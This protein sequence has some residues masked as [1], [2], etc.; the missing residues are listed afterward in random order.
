MAFREIPANPGLPEVTKG[1]FNI[2]QAVGGSEVGTGLP[3]ANRPTDMMLVYY[4]LFTIYR[5]GDKSKFP[6]HGHDGFSPASYPP[7]Q[8]YNDSRFKEKLSSLIYRFQSDVRKLGHPVFVDGRCDRGY[9][10]LTPHTHTFYT[11]NMLNTG[12]WTTIKSKYGRDDWQ[13]FLLQDPLTP[14]HLVQE[15]SSGPSPDLGF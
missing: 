2:D 10:S 5:D 13:D 3:A 11:I 4:F 12:Y 6:S 7:A 9:F 14:T 1:I 15:L 8:N